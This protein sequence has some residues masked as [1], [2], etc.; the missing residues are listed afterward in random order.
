[1]LVGLVLLQPVCLSGCRRL[2]DLIGKLGTYMVT[3]NQAPYA[4]VPVSLVASNF[5]RP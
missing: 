4:S 3:D 5:H 2:S 1:M